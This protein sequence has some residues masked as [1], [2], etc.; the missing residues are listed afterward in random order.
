MPTE[1]YKTYRKCMKELTRGREEGTLDDVAEERLLERMQDLWWQLTPKEQK[2]LDQRG[3]DSLTPP[4]D[5][6]GEWS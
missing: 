5:G 4:D 2:A 1:A 3:D 6:F